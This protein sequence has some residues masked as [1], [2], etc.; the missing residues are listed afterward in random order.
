MIFA[1][2]TPETFLPIQWG[3]AVIGGGIL[4]FWPFVKRFPKRMWRKITG[5]TEA[6]PPPASTEAT[7]ETVAAGEPSSTANT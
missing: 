4:T 2:L 5:R 1:Y 6:P 3:A 7:A